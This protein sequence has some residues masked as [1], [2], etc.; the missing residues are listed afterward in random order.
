MKKRS[1]C[2]SRFN[3]NIDGCVHTTDPKARG[4]KGARLRLAIAPV[5]EDKDRNTAAETC[6]TDSQ[7][8]RPHC[9]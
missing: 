9:R 8:L 1:V 5:L 6:V 2:L 4:A 7:T 3:V